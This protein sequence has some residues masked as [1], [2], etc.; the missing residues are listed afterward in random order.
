MFADKGIPVF[1][2]DEIAKEI[3]NTNSLLKNEIVTAF[4][5]KAYDKNKLNKEYLSDVVFNNE[6]LL[7]K[8]NSIVHP[9]VADEFNSWIQEQDSKYIIY[10]S[11]IIFE[12]QAEDFFDKI[13]CVTASEEEVISR[14]MK[15]NDFSVDKIK[16]IINKQL[17]N[18][19]KVQ[20]S[21]YVIESMNISK[22]S[23]KVL[24]IHNDIMGSI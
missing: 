24:E 10:E 19:A 3:M 5:D 15:R 22:L 11:A 1:N 16:S 13:I 20:K 7:K 14:I 8:I 18:D 4:G 12:N 23:D 21:D 17:P 6:I 9:Y 2:S